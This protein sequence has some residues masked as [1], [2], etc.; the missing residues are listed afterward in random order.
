MLVD[1]HSGI[2]FFRLGLGGQ[3]KALPSAVPPTPNSGLRAEPS[4]KTDSLSLL[5]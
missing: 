3:G 5:L 2:F 1:V 4:L